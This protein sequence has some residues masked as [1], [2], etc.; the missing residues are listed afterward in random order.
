[1]NRSGRSL[2]W[3]MAAAVALSA[4]LPFAPDALAAGQPVPVRAFAHDGYGRM[5]FDW[6]GPVGFTARIDG[7]K[8]VVTFDKEL[9]PGLGAVNANLG[10]Y[11][12]GGKLEADQ[13]TVSF[14]LKKP[15]TLKSFRIGNRVVLDLGEATQP[16][17][18]A[19]QAK[20]APAPAPAPASPP[21]SPPPAPV[22]APAQAVRAE[23]PAKAA[24]ASGPT[25]PVRAGN[26]PDYSRLVFDWPQAANYTLA[27]NGN[28]VTITF[29]KPG[30][31]DFSAV[32]RKP[33][34]FVKGVE[35]AQTDGRLAVT[36]T[37]PSDSGLKHF[38]NGSSLVLDVLK[39]AAIQP[40]AEP[41][42]ASMAG[43]APAPVA[44]AAPAPVPVPAPQPVPS[45]QPAPAPMQATVRP[46]APQ[47]SGQPGGVP[48]GVPAAMPAQVPIA[49]PPAA[50]AQHPV[51]A[52]PPAPATQPG[53]A[54]VTAAVGSAAAPPPASVTATPT[55]LTFATGGPAAVAVFTRSGYLYTVFDRKIEPSA[56]SLAGPV[57]ALVGPIETVATDSGSAFRIGLPPW[58]RPFIERDGVNWRV[59]LA[60]SSVPPPQALTVEPQPEF[61]LG[62]RLVVHALD[63]HNVVQITDPEVGDPLLVAPLSTPGRAVSE[64]HHYAQLELLPAIQGVVIR[65]IVE[66]I[67][68]RPVKEGLELTTAGGLRLSPST[69]ARIPQTSQSRPI[70][71][72]RLF[73]VAAWAKGT[74][75][76][77]T[78]NRQKMMAAVINVPDTE[79]EKARLD[80]ARFYFANGYGHEALGLLNMLAAEQPALEGWPEFRALRGATRIWTYD[81]EGAA[82]DLANAA[83]D[84]NPEAGL[85]RGAAAAGRRDWNAASREFSAGAHMLATYP[86]PHFLKL[87]LAAVEAKLNTGERPDAVRLLDQVVARHPDAEHHPA[88]LYLRGEAMRQSGNGIR[89]SELWDEVINSGDRYYRSRAAF[90]LINMEVADGRMT[91]RQ[92]TE[93]LEGLRFAWRGDDYELDVLQRA[94]EMHFMAGNYFDGLR[95]MRETIAYFPDDPRNGRLTDEM[96][97]VFT[98][99]FL[100]NGGAKLTALDALALYD[101]F[102]ELTPIGPQGDAIIRHLAERLV[103]IDL[104][105]RGAQLLEHQVNYRLAGM[106]KFQA[107][108]RLAA[109]RLLDH[110]PE[111]ALRALETS[112]IPGAPPDLAA[113]RRVLQARALAELNRGEEA[114]TLLG[115]DDSRP[116]NMLRVDIAWRG[117]RWGQAADALGKV[118]GP[119]PADGANL[120]ADTLQLVLNRAVALALSGDGVGLASFRKE[121][122]AVM[123]K[124]PEANAFYV[125]TRP[126]QAAGLFDA[127]TIRTRVA[128]VD[129]FKNF[130]DG[131]RNK[132]SQAPK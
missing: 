55:A 42:P 99:L 115:P 51:P 79:R 23:T 109:I 62:P 125:L 91:P 46:A 35:Q 33:P 119:P 47:P 5:V 85:W 100:K 73:D 95:T 19:V 78:E 76:T 57:E 16:P 74:P 60:R 92:A 56:V 8:L 103:E 106:D 108:T 61:V 17:P 89:A 37:V 71:E 38:K 77:F 121:W 20:A 75:K 21:A 72:R 131:Y 11:V 43:A 105:E 84:G 120:D 101:E 86:D 81:P 10:A 29:D 114:V 4:P 65:P 59:V 94:A 69:D 3:L 117:Q 53:V 96:T 45:P 54:P 132:Q 82:A 27:R 110:K 104:L 111:L 112:V 25:I 30:K 116:A 68:A 15:S 113:E 123:E 24:P 9:E 124:S 129:L 66:A 22:P 34:A 40:G 118:I 107:G 1:M 88:A 50:P 49:V 102:R 90:A 31:A 130:L 58:L 39:P 2:G 126:E 18:A 26:H 127:R 28:Q 13:R 44:K 52:A 12:S 98:D 87:S 36:V 67:N 32:S 41:S 7:Q 97:Q 122:G 6:S 70:E 64:R 128:E 93:K 80:L 83:L 48:V 14:D 63:A